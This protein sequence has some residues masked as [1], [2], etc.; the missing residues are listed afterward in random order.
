MKARMFD[1]LLSLL[2]QCAALLLIY[3]GMKE[4]TM[5]DEGAKTAVEGIVLLAWNVALG[6]RRP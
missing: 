6:F 4:T 3:L 5:L 2:G 1:A